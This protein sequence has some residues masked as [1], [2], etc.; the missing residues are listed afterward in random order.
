M[1]GECSVRAT[2]GGVFPQTPVVEHTG[3]E[4]GVVIVGAFREG[5]H[6]E[7]STPRQVVI[8][9]G[10]DYR[11]PQYV[12]SLDADERETRSDGC[13]AAG[14]LDV[15]FVWRQSKQL[16]GRLY[17]QYFPRLDRWGIHPGNAVIFECHAHAPCLQIQGV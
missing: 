9:I 16:R 10:T 3:G 7:F 4:V 5:E 15:N 8:Q 1:R 11:S 12:E 2:G 13:E 14:V 17:A 6:A